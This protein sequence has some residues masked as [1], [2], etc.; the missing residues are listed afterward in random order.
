M[1]WSTDSSVGVPE[2]FSPRVATT[3]KPVALVSTR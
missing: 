1:F 3:R 2:I